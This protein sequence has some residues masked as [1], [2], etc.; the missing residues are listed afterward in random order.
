MPGPHFAAP[1]RLP[2]YELPQQ[3]AR[4]EG[5]VRVPA[6]RQA[7]WMSAQPRLLGHR[8]SRLRV[9][10]D[11]AAQAR[12]REPI[13][14]GRSSDSAERHRANARRQLLALSRRRLE[15]GRNAGTDAHARADLERHPEP[16]AAGRGAKAPEAATSRVLLAGRPSAHTICIQ[17]REIR[18]VYRAAVYKR[19]GNARWLADA[20]GLHHRA[21]SVDRKLGVTQEAGFV[22]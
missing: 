20:G 11:A 8:L 15:P 6:A 10:R 4:P 14:E 13:R 22:P 2:R 16:A 17:T 5:D 18:W 1:Q 7:A 12:A 19:R 9:P 21:D 3:H